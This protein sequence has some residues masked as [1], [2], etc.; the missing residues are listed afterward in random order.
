MRDYKVIDT[1]IFGGE[2]EILKMRLDYLYD[3]VDYFIFS[4][5]NKTHNGTTKD[6]TYLQNINM[7]ES[8]KDKIHYVVFDPDITNLNLSVTPEDIFKSDLWKLERAQRSEVHSKVMELSDQSTMILHSDCDEFPDKSKFNELREMT[9]DLF[10]EVVSLGQPTYYYSP[11]NLLEI[12]WY[13]TVAFNHQTL[14]NLSDYFSVRE[15]RFQSNHLENSGWHFSFFVSPEEIQHKIQTYAHQEYNVP[16]IVNI[17]TIKYNIYNG[18]DVLNRPDVIIK[19]LDKISGDFPIEFYRHELFFK[20]TFDRVYLKPQTKLR[21]NGSMQIPLEIENLQ[22]SV[23]NQQPKIIVEIGTANGG[24]LS[25]WFEIPSVEIVISIDLPIGIH[26][27]Q[28]FEERTYVISDALEQAN[29]TNK[30]FFAINGNSKDYYIVERLREIL[31]GEKIDFLF[32]DGDHTYEGVK[33]DYELYEQFLN[34]NS[35]VGFHDIINSEYHAEHNCFVST[36]WSEIKKQYESVEF[37]YTNLL[38]K[39]ILEFFYNISNHKGGFGGIGYIEH[40]KK[41]DFSGNISLVVPIYNNVDDTI[42]NVSL[43]LLTS[44]YIDEVILYSNGTD[45][46]GNEKLKTFSQ[47]NS[48]IKLHIV[49]KPIGF[50]KAVNESFKLSKNEFILCLNSDAALYHN[51]EDMLIPFLND[52]LNGIIGPVKVRDFILGCCYIVKKSILNQIGLLNEGFGLGYCDDVEF[53]NRVEMNGYKLGYCEFKDDFGWTES[54]NF[55]IYHRQGSSF[56][57]LEDETKTNLN[58]RNEIKYYKFINTKKVVILKD[59]NYDDIKS[60]LNNEEVFIVV[61]KSGDNFEKIRYDKEII[62]LSNIFECT[63]D[64]DIN[65]IINS[66]AKGKEIE[67]RTN[68]KIIKDNMNRVDIIN[69]LIEKHNYNS[70][71]EIGVNNP[72]NC[73]NHI[74]CDLKHGVDPGVEG[75]YPVTYNMTSDEFFKINTLTYDIIFIDGLHIDEQ[76]E[77]DIYNSLSILN[78]NGTI[79]LHD[80]NPPQIY[81]AREDYGDKS[82]PVGDY[83][84]G[85]TW[86][87]FVKV[88]CEIDNIYASVVDTDWGVGIIQYSETPNKII[89]DNPYFSYNKFAENREKYLNLIS[90]EEFINQYI[91]E[92]PNKKKRLTWLA[93]YDDYASMGILSQKI[94]QN[95]KITDVSCKEII[96]VTETKN[97]LIHKLIKKP[98][99]HDLGIMFAYP[100]II[101]E[102]KQFN[103]KVIY[104]GVDTTEGIPNYTTNINQSDYILTPSNLSKDRMIKMGV[105]K[106]IFVFPHG[107]EKNEFVYKPRVMGDKFKFLYVGECSDRKGVFHLLRAFTELYKNNPNVELHLKSNSAMLFYGGDKVQKYV[108]ENSNIFWDKSDTGHERTLEL[109][110]EC[111]VYVY[112]SRADTFGMTI[113]EAMGCGL[114]VISTSEPGVTELVKGMY[115]DIPTNEVPVVGHPWMTGNWGEPNYLMLQLQ[116]R[117]IQENYS[118]FSNPEKLKKISEFVNENYCWEKITENFEKNILPKLTK[119]V[120]IITL[121]TS[122]KRPHH[123]KNVINSLKDVRE[124]GYTNDIYIVD[125]TNDDSKDEV[126]KI[127]NENIDDNFTLYSSS[128]NLGQRGALLQMLDDI[129]IDEYDFIQFTD[130][131]NLLLEPLSTYCNIL[132][133]NQDIFFATGYMSKEHNELGWRKTRFGNLCEKRSLR[134]GHMFMRVSDLKSLLPIHLDGQHGQPH[135]SSW[136]AGLDWEVSY[137]NPNSPGRTSNKNFVLCVPGG[138][139]HKGIDSTF[140]EWDVENNE[141]SLEELQNMRQK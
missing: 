106:P 8:Y 74:N 10:L 102:L 115:M 40:S 25:R 105:T 87:A 94:L 11:L 93:K 81:H 99:N 85:T 31:N 111:H 97:E 42:N 17:E 133:E 30:K 12:N 26:G 139:L 140:Y 28:G 68:K 72:D 127:I 22:L 109:Y 2:L 137:W 90:T 60:L 3:S 29:L 32:I 138:V 59:L 135:N 95:L 128:F 80:C 46:Y 123:I 110:N 44:K 71:L 96:G 1:F 66:V 62:E 70:Y 50:I 24:T 134:A 92:I 18:L 130:Q 126:T 15:N 53:S 122:Y 86:K 100:D 83:W 27:G 78:E 98:I 43:T 65:Q 91:A 118:D 37:V 108:D 39:N 41:K 6:L 4:E 129:N 55:P 7:F 51:W 89:N 120:K 75:Y 9:K 132:N 103:T 36:F 14:I 33:G 116:M 82:T 48:I 38:D 52:D 73:L 16:E 64:M 77:K 58:E 5:S 20:N 141:Y 21:K 121:L 69:S 112:P 104:T 136:Y 45:Q 23:A 79:V 114:P 84:T 124:D 119:E 67:F 19:K 34:E 35:I 49:D 47:S 63:N 113:L 61:N 117:T 125:N 107:I 88:R 57:L 76:V 101:G 131:D 56:E 13:G 54:V